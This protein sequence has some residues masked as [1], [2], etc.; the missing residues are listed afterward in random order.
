MRSTRPD[1]P[2]SW[3]PT[4]PDTA[5][6]VLV[7]GGLDSAILLGE[8]VR[9]YP[10]VTPI[11]V[12]VGSF[13]EPTE[14]AYLRR[15]LTAIAS[16]NLRPLVVVTQP[17]DDIYGPHWSITGA[18]PPAAD[19][20]DDAVFLPGRNVLL[21][22]KP[23]LWCHLN[24]VPEIATAPLVTNPFPDATDAFYDGFAGIVSQAVAGQ[25][26]VLRP[27]ASLGLRKVD[28]LRRGRGMPL[29]ETFSCIHPVHCLHCGAC[30]KCAERQLGFRDADMPDPTHY[31]QGQP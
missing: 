17:I 2:N 16:P 13:W 19:S 6:A 30:N 9:A 20:T 5:L 31:A 21:L 11:Y 12:R 27:Y 3:P 23:I 29:K 8:A 28:V 4:Q 14:E 18:N 15:F 1:D 24:G 7:S 26:R 25:V 10:Q 22:A